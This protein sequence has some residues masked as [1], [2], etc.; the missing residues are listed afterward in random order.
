M[1][2]RMFFDIPRHVYRLHASTA[3]HRIH[4]PSTLSFSA[5]H[6]LPTEYTFCTL[7][8]KM[9][10]VYSD[11]FTRALRS[12]GRTSSKRTVMLLVLQ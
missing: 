10:P 5:G 11:C 4:V 9:A 6:R 3:L 8:R 1:V 2:Y 7:Y 12:V